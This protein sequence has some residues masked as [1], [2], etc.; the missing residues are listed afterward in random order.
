MSTNTSWPSDV[1]TIPRIAFLVVCGTADTMLIFSPLA[2]LRNVDFPAEGLPIMLTSA[3][4]GPTGFT[5]VFS[6]SMREV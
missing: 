5:S 3:V 1:F 6:S 4:F 2:V